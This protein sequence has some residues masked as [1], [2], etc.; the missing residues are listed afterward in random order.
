MSTSINLGEDSYL[1]GAG[2]PTNF[3]VETNKAIQPLTII[4]VNEDDIDIDSLWIES[5]RR[6]FSRLDDVYCSPFAALTFLQRKPGVLS[7]FVFDG[8]REGHETK[9]L[10]SREYPLP[11]GPYVL[12]GSTIHPVYK[13]YPDPLGAFVCGVVP[14]SP[15]SNGYQ[16]VPMNYI[17]V[18]SRLYSPLPSPSLPLSGKR[19]AVKDIFDI[20]G[21]KTTLCSKAFEALQDISSKT[22]PSI[23]RLIDQGAVIIGKVKTTPFTSGM[24]P[25]D[26]VDYQAPFNPRGCGYL[27][28]DCSSSGSGAALAGY[29]WL[30]FT[31]GSDSLG[32][33]VGPAAANGLLGIRPTHGRISCEGLAPISSYLDTPGIFSRDISEFSAVTKSW[34]ATSDSTIPPAMPTKLTIFP[35]RFESFVPEVKRVMEDFI[36]DFEKAT[37]LSRTKI[38]VDELWAT[39]DRGRS[40]EK[41]FVQYFQNTLAHIQLYSHYNNTASFRADYRK[42]FGM[43][44]YAEPLLRYKWNLGAN[45]TE[46]QLAAALEEKEVFAQFVKEY[47]FDHGGVM[48]LPY[49]Q[50]DVFYR[51]EYSGSVEE[52]GAKW[53][54]FNVPVTAF[55]ALGGGPAVSIPVGQRIY[56]S[57]VTG[58]KEYQPVGLMLLGAPGT[59]EYLI[60]LVKHVL[61]ASDRPLSVKT[62]KVAF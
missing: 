11:P 15:G 32:S 45:L 33:M 26:W 52:W 38:N 29:E 50:P 5:K 51:D 21:I 47:I 46:Q 16:K 34:L 61:E 3:K 55:S 2:L 7:R 23:Q 1:L 62:G 37:Q 10:D 8:T 24:G 28:A 4:S 30:D 19:I 42:R 53:Q 9:L 36:Q 40:S 35:D 22:A 13:L 59:D 14:A 12:S 48:L 49:G 43:E 31:I 56:S 17:P 18:P 54:G 39:T 44:P 58:E 27:D 25:R 20:E 60:D 6:E 57:K 41:T